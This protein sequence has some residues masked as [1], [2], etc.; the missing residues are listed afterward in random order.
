MGVGVPI[1]I[2][3]PVTG[4]CLLGPI[5]RRMVKPPRWTC[6]GAACATVSTRVFRRT[7]V[8]SGHES[9]P[10]GTGWPNLRTSTVLGFVGAGGVGPELAVSLKLF[11]YDELSTRVHAV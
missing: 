7:G 1:S 8:T 2:A 6:S 9:T 10:S 11:R 5:R 4:R 3:F